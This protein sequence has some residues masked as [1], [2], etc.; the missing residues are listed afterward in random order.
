MKK[1][2][3]AFSSYLPAKRYG[4]PLKSIYN[5][6]ETTSD[7]FDY[8]LI[9]QNHDFRQTE[10][11]PGIQPGW[12]KV[13]KANVLYINETDYSYD[14]II[15]WMKECNAQMI[16]LCSV[17]YYQFNFPA[18]KAANTLGIPVLL[19]PR[20]D[21]LPNCIHHKFLKKFAYLSALRIIPKYK[22]IW[23]HSTSDEET[24]SILKWM[25]TDKDHIIQL[26][27]IASAPLDSKRTT[28]VKDEL[29]MV[30][31]GR[32]HPR[33]NLKY[34]V[35]CLARVN[36]KVSL[37]VYGAMED[38]G[39]WKECEAIAAGMDGDK[40]LRYCGVLSPLEVQMKYYQYDCLFFPTFNENY[41]HV[42]VEAIIA[43][44]PAL[45]SKGTTPWDDYDGEGGFCRELGRQEDFVEIIEAL[46]PIDND[47]YM[48]LVNKNKAYACA[49]FDNLKLCQKYKDVFNN[50]MCGN[51][52]I[53]A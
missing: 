1:A 30:F 47:E 6:V 41:G 34:A 14:N 37:D 51:A 52:L 3:F 29:R 4:G 11:L 27:N 23:Y 15:G 45:I 36:G 53:D 7:E 25:N 48:T 35:E 2:I 16:Y 12:N 50:I 21:L 9:S 22:G 38:E 43:G 44:C 10:L 40:E 33:K 31:I 17:Y 28:K 46:L 20:S 26:P 24:A 8:Y 42:I 49:H 5:L 18:V 39:Y 32:I 13:G 19:A